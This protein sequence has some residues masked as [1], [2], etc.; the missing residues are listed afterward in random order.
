MEKLLDLIPL[1]IAGIVFIVRAKV[2]REKKRLEEASISDKEVKMQL[3][4]Q[5]KG[6]AKK[7]TSQSISSKRVMDNKPFA[8]QEMVKEPPA[9]RVKDVKIEQSPKKHPKKK[10]FLNLT[11]KSDMI[12]LD[13]ILNRTRSFR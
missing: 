1:I 11:S 3:E 2:N 12:K 9:N 6:V 13:A 7:A 8:A 5:Q 10:S 4:A